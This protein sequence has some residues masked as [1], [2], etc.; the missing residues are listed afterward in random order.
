MRDEIEGKKKWTEFVVREDLARMKNFHDMRR[1]EPDNAPEN[2]E[3]QFITRQGDIKDILLNVANITGTKKSVA[4]LLDITQRKKAETAFH[5]SEKRFRTLFEL[6]TAVMILL[7]PET[8]NIID[9]I[10]RCRI[11]WVI[12]WK[13][14]AQ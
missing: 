1:N 11:L 14:Y 5:H 2:Y 3:F 10:F 8:G 9:A 4:S 6:N 7:D 12:P 13:L